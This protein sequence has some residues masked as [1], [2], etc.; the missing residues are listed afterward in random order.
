MSK[1]QEVKQTDI[2]RYKELASCLDRLQKNSDF[3]EFFVKHLFGEF[4]E[5][6]VDNLQEPTNPDAQNA[7]RFAIRN[8]QN[9]NWLKGY[10]N[11]VYDQAVEPEQEEN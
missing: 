11:F 5:S 4:V 10:I 3:K 8:I 2:A 6:N 7:V 9:V 1:L